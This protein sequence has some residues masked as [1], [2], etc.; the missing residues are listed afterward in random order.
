MPRCA[1]LLCVTLLFVASGVHAASV[2]PP[3]TGLLRN[4][5][6]AGV[7]ATARNG[8]LLR[9]LVSP[10]TAR[11]TVHALGD[12]PQ[13]LDASPIDPVE[14]HFA[15]YVPPTPGTTGYALLVFVPPWKDARVPIQWIPT[16]N[17]THTIFVTAAGSGNDA[18][19]L[20]RRDPLALL[21]AA[22]VMQRYS[23]NPAR[24]YVGGFSGGSRVALRLALGYPD[25][26]RGALLDAG[27]DPIGTAA[28]P[29]PPADLLH[30]FQARSRIVFLD[31][32]HD[33]IHQAQRARA[34]DALKHWCI[35]Q[36][37][38]LTLFDTPHVLASAAGFGAALAW[39]MRE[40]KP[41]P[42][43]R[44]TCRAARQAALAKSLAGVKAAIDAG[45]APHALQRL[46]E[47]DANYGN[48]AAPAILQN[49]HAIGA[50]SAH[51]DAPRP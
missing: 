8:E 11:R 27:S 9:R 15:V 21:A 7:P 31:G 42:A 5:T 29:L 25:V 49:L 30:T 22:G 19:V 16:L 14:Q 18:N 50:L 2:T 41:D 1:C 23:V 33:F 51:P 10:L 6:F 45:D 28:V 37:H 40:A 13:A 34:S 4:V 47:V 38:S 36:T 24:V 17:R 32:D 44:A 20:N 12:N 26:F 48:L 39:L 35:A 3:P 46:R 43:R